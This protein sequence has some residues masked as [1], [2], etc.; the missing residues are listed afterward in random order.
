M[1]T[2]KQLAREQPKKTDIFIK[3]AA[4]IVVWSKENWQQLAKVGVALLVLLSVGV[5][6]NL[7][8][9]SL[10]QKANAQLYRANQMLDLAKRKTA[11]EDLLK[12]FPNTPAA[13]YALLDL[14]RMYKAAGENEKAQQSFQALSKQ[15]Q[16]Q[17]MLYVSALF[18][19]ASLLVQAKEYEKA[20]MLYREASVYPK[21][22][23]PLTSSFQEALCYEQL[24]NFKKAQELHRIIVAS[25]MDKEQEIKERSEERLLWLAIND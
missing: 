13:N 5:G 1:S 6:I 9:K 8:N 16:A 22:L 7:Y 20:A 18:E 23:L 4:N 2:Y 19:E 17:P 14:G 25:K 21:N 15:S 12:D 3:T 11:L 10:A 24:G